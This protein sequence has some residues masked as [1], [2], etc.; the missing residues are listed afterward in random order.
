MDNSKTHFK[1]SFLRNISLES[2]SG[3]Y[4]LDLFKL[5][6]ISNLDARSKTSFSVGSN[7][8]KSDF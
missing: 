2:L 3:F 8:E 5:L 4:D 1:A 6:I 7:D